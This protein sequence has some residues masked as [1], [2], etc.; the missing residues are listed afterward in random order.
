MARPPPLQTANSRQGKAELSGADR[1]NLGVIKSADDL[2]GPKGR[3]MFWVFPKKRSLFTSN[4]VTRALTNRQDTSFP[5][6]VMFTEN[7]PSSVSHTTF[8]TKLDSTDSDCFF[9]SILILVC[10]TTQFFLVENL[11]QGPVVDS[12]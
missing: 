9:I 5:N 1:G 7:G 11:F 6:T 4:L 8:R 12:P 2:R 3:P 10:H